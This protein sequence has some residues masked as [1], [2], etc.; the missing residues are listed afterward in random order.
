[1]SALF[2]S[3]LACLSWLLPLHNEPWPTFYQEL[4]YSCLLI[5]LLCGLLLKSNGPWFVDCVSL[6]FF[7]LIVFV[8]VQAVLGV[9]V[10]PEES[11]LICAYL[12]LCFLSVSMGYKIASSGEA[13]F[14]SLL[15]GS[16]L[17]ASVGSAIIS[18]YQWLGFEFLGVFVVSVEGGGRF[19]ANLAQPNNLA[20]LLVWGG[21]SLWWFHSRKLISG[22]FC[23]LLAFLLFWGLAL[24]GSRSGMMQVFIFSAILFFARIYAKS[25]EVRVPLWFPFFCFGWVAVLSFLL[26][27][28]LNDFFSQE[29]RDFFD[30]TTAG[31]RFDFWKM[32]LYA[33]Y[34]APLLGYGWN[35][36]V[37]V[38]LSYADVFNDLA[39]VMGHS[40]N[41]VIDVLI[42]NG[43]LFGALIIAALAFWLR[44]QVV[45]AF[46]I[47]SI[48]IL[49][50]L[51][52]FFVH[53][54][55]ELP[56]LYLFF[57][58]PVCFFVG[59]LSFYSGFVGGVYIPRFFIF[60]VAFLCCAS[61]WQVFREYRYIEDY[62]AAH[63]ID[64]AR[65]ANVVY[66]KSIDFVY[67]GFLRDVLDFSRVEPVRNMGADKMDSIRR[68][69]MRYPSAS[70]LSRYAESLALNGDLIQ[71]AK[72]LK[73]ICDLRGASAC[74]SAISAWRARAML[75]R[76]EMNYVTLPATA[77]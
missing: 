55:L 45:I 48:F 17:V 13:W 8:V 4:L 12:F 3:F 74:A 42:W 35:Q 6:C 38:H 69:A 33:L 16:L 11:L 37:A 58:I 52:V 20:T 50:F 47:R 34:N 56:H 49:S 43:V 67:L 70:L 29:A 44:R 21:I 57:I 65:I 73:L 31:V 68:A 64:M 63:K 41:L 32:S 39:G 54:L 10:F 18:I 30:L 27:P 23:L 19:S 46:D 51:A 9:Y 25:P 40:H 59:L 7:I 60:G 1:M 71:A 14:F 26:I 24:S 28:L 22:V 2:F 15:F 61:L 53:A 62:S 75:G 36:S 77:P 72:V 76:W 66:P 5:C